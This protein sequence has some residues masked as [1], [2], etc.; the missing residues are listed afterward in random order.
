MH[1]KQSQPSRSH[2]D[3]PEDPQ[4]TWRFGLERLLMGVLMTEGERLPGGVRP[5]ESV[6][7]GA[8]QLVGRF[9]HFCGTLFDQLD[10]DGGGSVDVEEFVDWFGDDGDAADVAARRVDDGRDPYSDVVLL[11]RQSALWDVG[12]RGLLDEFWHLTDED[13]SGAVDQQ[14]YVKLSMQLQKYW[15]ESLGEPLSHAPLA[16]GRWLSTM[17]THAIVFGASPTRSSL[18]P[19]PSP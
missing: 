18:P 17:S 4:N 13:A 8:T 7:G 11:K 15:Y 9:A 6:E 19:A 12:V 16:S 14:E 1:C 3:Q 5:F 2:H 10:A